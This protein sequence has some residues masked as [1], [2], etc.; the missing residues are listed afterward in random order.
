MKT[1][2]I[3]QKNGLKTIG[4]IGLLMTLSLFS[5]SL[6]AQT[7]RTVTGIVSDEVGPLENATVVLKG[8][9]VGIDTDEDGTF[10]F[11]QKLKEDD[12]LVVIQLGYKKKEITIGADT[13]FVDVKL[14]DYDIIIVGSLMMGN[15][16]T[17]TKEQHR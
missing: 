7:E 9:S 16:K 4:F 17:I 10:T 1:Q 3:T 6:S 5:N 8:T 14:T 12:T 13:S 11:P 2:T 15:N